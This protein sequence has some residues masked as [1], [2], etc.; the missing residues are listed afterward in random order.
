MDSTRTTST[1][2]SFSN[3]TLIRNSNSKNQQIG[4]RG[5][6]LLGR[7]PDTKR[8]GARFLVATLSRFSNLTRTRRS[9]GRTS[10]SHVSSVSREGTGTHRRRHRQRSTTNKHLFRHFLDEVAGTLSLRRR[11]CGTRPISPIDIRIVCFS[12]H[13]VAPATQQNQ[14]L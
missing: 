12:A 4:P 3:T 2:S 9:S 7:K 6:N 1:S 10:V 8:P 11:R 5:P 14:G 13:E